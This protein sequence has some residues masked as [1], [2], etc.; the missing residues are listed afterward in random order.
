MYK[1][2]T[3]RAASV[4]K[5][6]QWIQKTRQMKGMKIKDNTS[7]ISLTIMQVSPQILVYLLEEA[8]SLVVVKSTLYSVL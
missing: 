2:Q 3:I 8:I 5:C 6:Y 4:G 7:F 1:D